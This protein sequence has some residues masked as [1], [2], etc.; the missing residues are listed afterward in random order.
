[1]KYISIEIVFKKYKL[2]ISV[3]IPLQISNTSTN[4]DIQNWCGGCSSSPHWN[5]STVSNQNCLFCPLNIVI[6]GNPIKKLWW[7]QI[8]TF[9]GEFKCSLFCS[10][11]IIITRNPIKKLRLCNTII[12]RIGLGG[13]IFYKQFC[14]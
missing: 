6:R 1:M 14:D 4:L 10:L 2:S 7:T 3:E 13:P 9:F 5:I 12:R 11:N 8:S